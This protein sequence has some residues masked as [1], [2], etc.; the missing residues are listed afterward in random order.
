MAK[1]M[2]KVDR[3]TTFAEVIP[4]ETELFLNPGNSRV[5]SNEKD[6]EEFV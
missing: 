5:K 2:I 3:K 1:A 6:T 4:K